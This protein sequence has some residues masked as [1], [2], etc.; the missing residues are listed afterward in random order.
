MATFEPVRLGILGTAD[1]N[2]KLL[3]GASLTDAVR[4]VAVG[5]RTE[6]RAQAFATTF[7]IPRAHP[8]YE[9]LLADAD[10]EAVYISLPNALHHEWSM[11]ALASGKHVL[12]EKPY[13]RHPENVTAAFDAAESAGLILSEAFMWRHHPQAARLRELLPGLGRLQTIRASFS[14]V[15]DR[16]ADI[17]LSADL[18]GGSLMDVGCYCVSGARY[19]SGEEPELVFGT[20]VGERGGVD[21]R[22]TGVLRFP[23]GVIAEFTSAFTTDHRGLEL[24]G[25]DGTILFTD[26]WQSLPATVIV[27]GVESAFEEVDPYQCEIDN[28]SAAIRGE[29]EPLLG[30]ADALG[31]A[32]AIDALMRS[33]AGGTGVRL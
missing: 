24:I 4:V 10:V 5:S 29:A 3:K 15:L 9:A 19:A 18:D 25:T 33:A 31:Q 13:S 2:R 8:T 22:F 1:I 11:R 6:A 7:G 23:S 12:C 16:E 27:D 21:R 14:F 17:R 32:R 26:P 30:R 20:S 28:L